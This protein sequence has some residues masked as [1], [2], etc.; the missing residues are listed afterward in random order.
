M[1]SGSGNAR[2]VALATTAVLLLSACGGGG[3]DDDAAGQAGDG[4][5]AG[6]VLDSAPP[7][8]SAVVESTTVTPISNETT[9]TT[10][11]TTAAP[12]AETTTTTTTTAPA[13]ATTAPAVTVPETTAEPTSTEPSGGVPVGY[14]AIV[15]D[16]GEVR[17]NVPAA[18]AQT[19]G[20]PDGELRQ[21][22][23]APDLAGFLAGYTQVGMILITGVSATPDSWMDGLATTVGIAETDGCTIGETSEYSDGV[24][25]GTEN[26]LSCGDPATVTHII[27]GRN[28]D[29]DLFFLLAIVRPADDLDV[30]DQIVQSF[31]ID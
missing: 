10:T 25:T 3:S 12:A 11:S 28:S 13:P 31:F 14:V 4:G 24:Y 16:S 29:G 1:N 9:T 18:W 21:L 17:A 8:E 22:A 23:G 15:D 27:G 19:D 7:V 30:R 26:V 6:I 20:A 2:F 5:Q